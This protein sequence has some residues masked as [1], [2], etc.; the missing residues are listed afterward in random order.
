MTPCG[1]LPPHPFSVP[2]GVSIPRPVRTITAPAVQHLLHVYTPGRT[3]NHGTFHLGGYTT[4]HTVA[5]YICAVLCGALCCCRAPSCRESAMLPRAPSCREMRRH[6]APERHRAAPPRCAA[7]PHHAGGTFHPLRARADAR[8]QHLLLRYAC[9]QPLLLC[10]PA[11]PLHET[12]ER[13]RM[14]ILGGSLSPMGPPGPPGPFMAPPLGTMMSCHCAPFPAAR[15]GADVRT[16][17]C[18]AYVHTRV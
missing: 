9:L 15:R 11:V 2:Q 12:M 5:W 6:A 17:S 4:I 13:A 1:A 8:L 10:H 3:C 18:A 16:R 7:P 14:T